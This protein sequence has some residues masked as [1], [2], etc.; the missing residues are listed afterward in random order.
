MVAW[1]LAA[2]VF[3][4]MA[5]TQAGPLRRAKLDL[6]QASA[7][8]LAEANARGVDT[9]EVAPLLAQALQELEAKEEEEASAKKAAK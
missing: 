9:S 2:L 7:E 3:R 4:G 6:E 8:A 1:W 5:R